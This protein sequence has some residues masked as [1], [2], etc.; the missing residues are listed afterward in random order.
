MDVI[1]AGDPANSFML[2]KLDATPDV[3]CSVLT[4]AANMTCLLP[5]P[6][7]DAQLSLAT[8][9]IIRRWITQGAKND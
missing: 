3:N 7:D 9:D 4:C 8:R 2:Y 5:M 1:K 6:Y